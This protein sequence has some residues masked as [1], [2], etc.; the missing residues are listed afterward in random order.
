MRSSL[1]SSLAVAQPSNV[2]TAERRAILTVAHQLRPHGTG[3]VP[4]LKLM[5]D[6]LDLAGFPT[7]T[8]AV[9]HAANGR[10]VIEA[11]GH[12]SDPGAS[13]RRDRLRRSLAGS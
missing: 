12:L 1:D 6:W 11:Q 9:L 13:D 7:G 2:P 10:I 5:G 3:G 8:Y 4:V